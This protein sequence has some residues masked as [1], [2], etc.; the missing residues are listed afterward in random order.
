MNTKTKLF[1]VGMVA[2]LGLFMSVNT[3]SAQMFIGAPNV[4]T[5][6]AT[7]IGNNTVTLN[8]YVSSINNAN[9]YAWFEWGINSYYGNQTNQVDYGANIGTSYS[10]YLSGLSE[11]TVY[12]FRA[13]AENNNGQITYGNQMTFTTTGNTCP[14][15]NCYASQPIVTTYSAT[16]INDTSAM[17]NGN[18]DPNGYYATRW[19]EWGTNSGYFYNSTNKINSSYP[20]NFSELLYNL[21]PG[22]TYYYRATAQNG[23]GIPVYGNVSVFIT[24][25]KITANVYVTPTTTTTT[26]TPVNTE[27]P[28]Q[29]IIK[30]SAKNGA[31]TDNAQKTT[32]PAEETSVV[33]QGALAVLLGGNFLPNSLLGWLLIILLLNL[34]ILA[35]RKTYYGTK[36]VAS[37][38]PENTKEK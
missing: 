2:F 9:V 13:V 19:F 37:P 21:N 18:V 16:G 6:L 7:N 15:Y 25:P 1:I 31:T 29:S 14:S 27:P 4:T 38:V 36:M 22:T 17:L 34:L 30:N 8:G 33:Q 20:V 28:A 3:V 23:N 10:Y 24:S 26:T 5:N 32:A 11:N 12:Y 35:A